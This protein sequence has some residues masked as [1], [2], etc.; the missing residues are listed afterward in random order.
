MYREEILNDMREMYWTIEGA[1][2]GWRCPDCGW[3]IITTYIDPIYS[4]V[5]EYSLYVRNVLKIDREKIKLVAKTAGVNF[6]IAKQ[7]LEE[8]NVCI[9]KAKAPEIKAAVVK[10]RELGVDFNI[11]PTFK[12]I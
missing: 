7:M 11:S 6:I 12:Y 9:L 3:S 5:T 1:T 2:Q 4:D 8:N 10:L